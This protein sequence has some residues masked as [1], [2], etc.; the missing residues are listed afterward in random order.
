MGN[1]VQKTSTKM[2]AAE[3]VKFIPN[4]SVTSNKVNETIMDYGRFVDNTTS[5]TLSPTYEH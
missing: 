3:L 1:S 4:Q 5:K 2:S